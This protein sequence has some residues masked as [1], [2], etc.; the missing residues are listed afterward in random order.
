M[1]D[2]FRVAYVDLATPSLSE[3]TAY[4]RDVIGATVVESTEGSSYLSLGL[5]HHNVALF[6][7]PRPKLLSI[8]LQLTKEVSLKDVAARLRDAGLAYEETTDRKPGVSQMLEVAVGGHRFQF[9][10]SI[11]QPAPGFGSRGVVPHRLGHVAIMSPDARGILDFLVRVV[12]FWT[13]DWFEDRVTFVTCNRDHHAINVIEAP[14]VALHHLAFEM[15]SRDHQA[16]ASDLLARHGRPLLWG[17]SRHTAGHNLATYH[18]GADDVLVEFYADM[19]VYLPDLDSFEPR[20]WHPD[21][22]Q[23]PKRWG[24]DEMTAW[25][26]SFGFDFLTVAWGVSE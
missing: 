3:A 25:R 2:V 22:P 7:A 16:E 23:K 19:D 4:Y 1:P 9:F 26:T 20:P 15:R 14:V 10:Q 11:E 8:G 18:S 5:D 6:Q 12:G 21:L 24:L 17:P 13:T